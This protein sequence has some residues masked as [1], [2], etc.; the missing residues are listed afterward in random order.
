MAPKTPTSNTSR[1]FGLR[2]IFR[3][4]KL[5]AVL[6]SVVILSATTPQNQHPEDSG[7]MSDRDRLSTGLR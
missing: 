4:V 1:T 6:D 2:R 7:D 3:L 5:E